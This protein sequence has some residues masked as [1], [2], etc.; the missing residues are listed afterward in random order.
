MN[1]IMSSLRRLVRPAA[2]IL[3]AAALT[4]AA[5]RILTAALRPA[6]IYTGVALLLV[7]LALTLFNGRKKLPFLP[8]GS[9]KA[10]LRFHVATGWFSVFLFG[11]HLHWAWPRGAFNSV[12]AVVFLVVALS[13]VA[14]LWLSRHLPPRLARSGEPLTYERIPRLREELREEI[15][16]L[17]LTETVSAGDSSTFG[18]FYAGRLHSSLHRPTPWLLALRTEDAAHR[19]LVADLSALRRYMNDSER[20]RADQL[21]ALLDAK[22]NLDLQASAQRLLKLWLFIHIPFTYSLLLLVAAHV[23][24]VLAYRSAW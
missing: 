17:C 21:D 9:A 5:D 1:T 24:I 2:W 6:A 18:D 16:R 3:L 13:G 20:A 19:A 22:R 14:G 7:C 12:L 23:L 15:R 4:Y 11:C 8:L 10:W